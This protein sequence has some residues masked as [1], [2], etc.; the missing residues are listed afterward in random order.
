MNFIK[1]Q[2]SLLIIRNIYLSS[3]NV[4]IKPVSLKG[5]VN[6]RLNCITLLKIVFL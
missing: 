3:D 5:G 1:F 4:K 6:L 2:V